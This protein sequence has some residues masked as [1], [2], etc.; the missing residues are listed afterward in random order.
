M[1]DQC[2]LHIGTEKTGTSSIQ[3]FLATNRERL[4][5]HKYL[6]PKSPGVV[7]HLGLTC[8]A[9]DDDK[10]DRVRR[11]RVIFSPDDV[12]RYRAKLL[13]ELDTE[14]GESRAA[15]VIF[16]NEH[17]SS[18]LISHAEIRR[19][20][21]LCDKYAVK[22]RVIVYIRDQVGFLT[23]R[24]I[25]GVKGGGIRPLT[26]PI[27]AGLIRLMDYE[28]LL[29]PWRE[30]FGF[31]NLTVRRFVTEDFFAG[32]LLQDFESHIGIPAG[33]IETTRRRNTALS[34]ECVD[35]L[36][37]FNKY[38]PHVLGN[39]RNPLRGNVVSFLEQIEG[40]TPFQAPQDIAA[41]LD[42]M[43]RNSNEIVSRE[44]FNS[45]YQPLFERAP[46]VPTILSAT[47]EDRLSELIRIAAH[48]WTQ[49]QQDSLDRKPSSN[50][51]I[52]N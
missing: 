17:L 47:P 33:T 9:Q 21:G 19:I 51:N 42:S 37:Q 32:D 34:T 18:R 15:A 13:A 30:V 5:R 29:A 6:Y 25:E 41:H 12:I 52:G 49:Q 44:Y 3:D 28:K 11:S 23:S 14:I 39:R 10:F 20:K 27:R 50:S 31:E 26:L 2:F 16:S 36:L 43:F 24:Y 35:F 45:R 22:T 8:Y 46:T 1:I 48:L 7:N 40:G 38:V 4:L